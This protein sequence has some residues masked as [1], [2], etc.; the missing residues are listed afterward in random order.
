MPA[1]RS[2]LIVLSL[3]AI[4]GQIGRIDAK[5]PTKQEIIQAN[6]LAAQLLK[7]DDDARNQFAIEHPGVLPESGLRLPKATAVAFDWCNL[8]MVGQWRRQRSEDCWANSATEALECSNLIRNNRRQTL[9]V[10]PILDNLKQGAT[11]ETMGGQ[12]GQACDFFLKTG[13]AR[14]AVYRYTGKPEDPQDKPLPYRAVAWGYVT[15]DGERPTNEQIKAALLEHGPLAVDLVDTVNF[16]AYQ[17][18]L[19]NEST[20]L[21]K[22]DIKGK[23]AVLLVGWDDTRGPK[24][25]WKIKNSWGP[26]WGEQGFMWLAY[27]S[28]DIARHVEWVCAASTFYNLPVDTFAQLV[29]EAKPLPPV[30]YTEVAQTEP[31]DKPAVTTLAR[32][33]KPGLPIKSGEWVESAKD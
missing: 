32:V 9:S 4:L 11:K 23:H 7:L 8:N 21:D 18:G 13:T 5:P 19:Y 3:V 14:A 29:P 26:N 2:I 12:P 24:G 31:T 20:P 30:H 6:T 28:N 10:Q 27:G 16:H 17:G 25:A 1:N 33:S 15:N 22:K